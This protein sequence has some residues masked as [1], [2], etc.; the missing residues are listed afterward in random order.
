MSAIAT[1]LDATSFSE[2]TTRRKC[3]IGGLGALTPIILN[4]LVVDLQTTFKA[5]TAL[6]LIG[7]LIRVMI[8]FYLGGLVAYLHKDEKSIL[9]LFELG[10]VAPALITALMNGTTNLKSSNVLASTQP[11]AVTA[12]ITDF[13]IPTAYAQ[14]EQQTVKVYKPTEESVTSQLWR[15]ISGTQNE[16]VWYVVVGTYRLNELQKARDLARNINQKSTFKADVYKNDKYY[17]V[18]IGANLELQQ[19][20]RLQQKATNE[21]IPT[22][23]DIYL[24]N[25]WSSK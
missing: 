9:K 10:I 23:G 7:Y 22:F 12:G 3:L 24:Y 19:A 2:L 18:V 16:N 4:L 13:F 25:P 11:A 21:E 15:G 1:T 8:L 17:A 6:V 20:K 5:L 14:V